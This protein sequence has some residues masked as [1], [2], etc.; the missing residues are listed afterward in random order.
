MEVIFDI[1]DF[2]NKKEILKAVSKTLDLFND[3]KLMRQINNSND[4]YVSKI[5]VSNKIFFNKCDCRD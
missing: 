1:K 5:G 3:E 4:V 2:S